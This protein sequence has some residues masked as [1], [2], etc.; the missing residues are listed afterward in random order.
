LKFH[1]SFDN[2]QVAPV[3]HGHRMDEY[4]MKIPSTEL[5]CLCFQLA[6]GWGVE[7]LAEQNDGPE[8]LGF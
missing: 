6:A 3:R 8:H 2:R 7:I 4:R 1:G 5:K